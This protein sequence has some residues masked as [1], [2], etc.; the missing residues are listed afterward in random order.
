MLLLSC[1]PRTSLLARLLRRAFHD[2][3]WPGWEVVIGIEAHVQIKSRQKLFSRSYFVTRRVPLTSKTKESLSSSLKDPPNTNVS[4]FD[5]AFPGTLPV[6]GLL[7]DYNA[8]PNSE[9]RDSTKN[10]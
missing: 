5:A 10:V 1:P 3:R 6:R 9:S 4:P 7:S 2:Q 8:I